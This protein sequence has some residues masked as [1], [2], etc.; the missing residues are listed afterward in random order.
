MSLFKATVLLITIA[1]FG[2]RLQDYLKILDIAPAQ[3]L[4]RKLLTCA[5]WLL[6]SVAV[7]FDI[8]EIYQAI[9]GALGGQ[10]YAQLI[11]RVDVYLLFLVLGLITAGA[12]NSMLAEYWIGGRPGLVVLGAAI[13]TTF[14]SFALGAF[15]GA[16]A[17]DPYGNPAGWIYSLAWQLYLAYISIV[18]LTATLPLAFRPSADKLRRAAAWVN[19]AAYFIVAV[20]PAIKSI[21]VANGNLPDTPT[22]I[23]KMSFVLLIC[24]GMLMIWYPGKR[25][26][27]EKTKICC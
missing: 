21:Q 26:D 7:A 19:S 15:N 23:M 1:C 3:L 25:S 11:M 14:T 24:F 17:P 4:R 27:R 9:D 12:F 6:L 5:A 8:P 22:E 18:L 13:G 10:N 16:T 2:I 20:Y